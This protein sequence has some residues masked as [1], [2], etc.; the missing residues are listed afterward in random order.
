[1]VRKNFI[2]PWIRL[3]ITFLSG[4]GDLPLRSIPWPSAERM[5]KI[6]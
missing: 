3:V 2:R 5:W 6:N 4:F 1:V